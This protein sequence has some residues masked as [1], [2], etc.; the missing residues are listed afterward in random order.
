MYATNAYGFYRI[1][2][3]IFF[4]NLVPIVFLNQTIK[5]SHFLKIII[6]DAF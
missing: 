1:E 2:C 3:T 4:M 5:P 6:L